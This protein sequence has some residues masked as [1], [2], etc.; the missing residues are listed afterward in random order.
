MTQAH[1][2][3][4]GHNRPHRMELWDMAEVRAWWEQWQARK[5]EYDD[6]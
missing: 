2:H 1:C 6:A 5:A 4:C 3:V